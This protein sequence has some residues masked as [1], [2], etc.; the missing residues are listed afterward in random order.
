MPLLTLNFS[1]ENVKYPARKHFEKTNTFKRQNV[2]KTSEKE[3]VK[4]GEKRSWS[5]CNML[6]QQNTAQEICISI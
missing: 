5:N 3:T 2:Q 6:V 1:C 4:T